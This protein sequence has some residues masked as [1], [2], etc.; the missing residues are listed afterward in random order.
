MKTVRTMGSST[1]QFQACSCYRFALTPQNPH[2][3]RWW[4]S[5]YLCVASW[6]G[7]P[8]RMH[9]YPQNVT[10]FGNTVFADV[11]K[12]MI[13]MRSYLIIEW[14]PNPMWVSL[15]GD[16]KGHREEGST[17]TEA[18]TVVRPVRVTECRKLL[19]ITRS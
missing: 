2:E 18:E 17:N 9:A 12:V 1:L 5:C 13:M 10:L 8:L 16:R 15:S 7:S 14:A 4:V 11:I 3:L 19:A 6:T